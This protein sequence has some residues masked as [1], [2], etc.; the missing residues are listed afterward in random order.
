MGRAKQKT[1][2]QKLAKRM[3]ELSGVGFPMA[4]AR[5]A[6]F[7]LKDV[8]NHTDAD[9]RHM[10]RSSETKTIR[11]KTRIEKLRDAGVIDRD[12]AEACDWYLEAHTMGYETL[13]IV[14]DYG[15]SGSGSGGAY[16]HLARYKAQQ[17]AREDYA[18][19]RAGIEPW[20]ISLFERVV[21]HG[22]SL[23]A[24]GG[25]KVTPQFR[26]A[27]WQLHGRI[28]HMLPIAA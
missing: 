6:D 15:R 7:V 24:N 2:E 22:D 23:N 20:L 28:A 9:Q 8:Q 18:F 12:Q 13:G 16:S 10:V 11:R 14:A 5:T 3:R 4:Q 19:A 26:L 25:S 17:E 27:A 21:L 1:P